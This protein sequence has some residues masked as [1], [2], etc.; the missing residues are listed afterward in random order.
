MSKI[1]VKK[2]YNR[3]LKSFFLKF[4]LIFFEIIVFLEKPGKN[5]DFTNW[6][7]KFLEDYKKK[8]I[9]KLNNDS[10]TTPEHNNNILT[11]EEKEKIN[12][13]SK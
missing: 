7:W 2:K 4:N 13:K 12:S 11:N 5:S 8:N 3:I 1:K 10:K 9:D 6:L